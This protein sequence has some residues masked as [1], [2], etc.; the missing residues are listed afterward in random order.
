MGVRHR[1]VSIETTKTLLDAFFESAKN[2]KENSTRLLRMLAAALDREV[3]HHEQYVDR[4]HH[5]PILP[6][7]LQLVRAFFDKTNAQIA[8]N[9]QLRRNA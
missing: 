3:I 1:M 8:R 4:R 5:M 6:E 9:E 2:D 7:V